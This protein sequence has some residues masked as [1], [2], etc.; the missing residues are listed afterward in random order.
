MRVVSSFS[1]I[2][3]YELDVSYVHATLV[4]LDV[5]CMQHQSDQDCIQAV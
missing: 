2:R 1:D 4:T 3:S 5:V